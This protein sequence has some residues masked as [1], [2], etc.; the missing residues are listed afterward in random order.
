MNT[1]H[2]VIFA[3]ILIFI[4]T[5]GSAY[6]FKEE[7]KPIEIHNPQRKIERQLSTPDLTSFNQSKADENE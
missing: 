4:C 3:I 2:Y 7:P 5:L 1:R 6:A